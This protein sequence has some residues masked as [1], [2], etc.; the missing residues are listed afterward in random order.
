M[1]LTVLFILFYILIWEPYLE[2]M[3]DLA[4]YSWITSAVLLCQFLTPPQIR[5]EIFL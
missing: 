4:N 5:C 1:K 2:A 3:E